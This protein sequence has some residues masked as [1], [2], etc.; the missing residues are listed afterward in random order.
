MKNTILILLLVF[1]INLSSQESIFS[2]S[3]FQDLKLAILKDD[4]GNKP[5]T[6]DLLIKSSLRSGNITSS[7]NYENSDLK[8]SYQRFSLGLG[9]IKDIKKWTISGEVDLISVIKRENKPATLSYGV[10][11]SIMYNIGSFSF[12]V[13]QQYVRRTD[14]KKNRHS[15]FVG[16]KYKFKN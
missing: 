1:S 6:R 10:N 9:Y 16:I 14:V 13:M 15:F 4:Y 12:G 11:G 5:Y 2:V 8:K 3:V 7:I